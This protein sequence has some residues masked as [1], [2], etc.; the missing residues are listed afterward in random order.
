[1]RDYHFY[2]LYLGEIAQIK[3]LLGKWDD[4]I[5]MLEEEIRIL[6][7]INYCGTSILYAKN[8][9]AWNLVGKND[10]DTALDIFL[11]NACIFRSLDGVK[12]LADS[13]YGLAR[14]YITK[15]KFGEAYNCAVESYDLYC[16]HNDLYGSCFVGLELGFMMVM[17]GDSEKGLEILNR[18]KTGFEKLEQPQN[19]AK[20][21]QLIDQAEQFIQSQGEK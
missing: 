20:V 17:R 19:V 6:E 10:I 1:M 11:E 12:Y 5:E 2:A 21:Q 9:I 18:S 8:K 4:S 13:L 14:V 15:E 7:S 16:K 3:Q